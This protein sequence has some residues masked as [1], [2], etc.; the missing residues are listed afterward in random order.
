M[1]W[2]EG[3]Q[4]GSRMMEMVGRIFT[5]VKLSPE[6]WIKLARSAFSRLQF[7]LWSRREISLRTKSRVYQAVVT[8]KNYPK[9]KLACLLDGEIGLESA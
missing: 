6:S 1:A 5:T 8:S 4:F 7:C 9:I 2:I 3:R